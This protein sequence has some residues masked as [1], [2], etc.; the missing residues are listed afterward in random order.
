MKLYLHFGYHK[1]G[2]SFLQTLF[3]QN[4]DSLK[5]KDILYPHS[6]FDKQMLNAKVSPGNGLELTMA[7]RN[8]DTLKVEKLFK[9]W[10]KKCQSNNCNKLLISNEGLFHNFRDPSAFKILE[11]SAVNYGFTDIYGLLY[12]RDPFD[13]ALSL[14]KHRSKNGNI[15]DFREWLENEYETLELIKQFLSNHDKLAIKWT[16]RKYKADSEYMAKSVFKDWLGVKTP[17]LSKEEKVNVSMTLSE[18]LL[19]KEC[20]K[21]IPNEYLVFLSKELLELPKDKKAND[22]LLK[23]RFQILSINFFRKY[24]NIINDVN[25]L[26]PED[27]KLVIN[28]EVTV[29]KEKIDKEILL[30]SMEQINVIIKLI[31]NLYNKPIS[32]E[33]IKIKLRKL[34]RLF[35]FNKK[36]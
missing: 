27:E 11:K 20:Q 7:L 32:K 15:I 1:T 8:R 28:T 9:K 30:Y 6:S 25:K 26:L 19:L 17:I 23:K 22:D 24:E 2:S 14:Y 5:S 3:A 13:H 16:L 21:I 29:Y 12:L 35:K 33:K 18:I 10:L 4:R 34:K 36:S 31:V